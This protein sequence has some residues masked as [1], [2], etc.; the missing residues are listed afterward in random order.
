MISSAI[1]EHL[2]ENEI[3]THFL[4]KISETEMLVKKVDIIK[5]LKLSSEISQPEVL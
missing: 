2:K 4:E 5:K 3:P 1:F